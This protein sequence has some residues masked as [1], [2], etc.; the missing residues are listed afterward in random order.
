MAPLPQHPGGG[1]VEAL[2]LDHRRLARRLAQRYVRNGDQREDLEQAAYLGLVKAARRFDP[3]RGVAFTTFAV[4]TVLGELRRFC[5]DTRWAVHV[6]RAIQEHVQAFRKVEDELLLVHGR[7]PSVAEM[8]EALGWSQEDVLDAREAAGCL[9]PQSLNAPMRSA[10]DTIGEAIECI[11]DD[12]R[13]FAAVEQRDELHCALAL[14]SARE[15]RAVQL[16]GEGGCSTPEIARHLG[17]S[18]PQ[19]A[20]LVAHSIRRLRDAFDEIATTGATQPE[21]F[22]RLADADPDL[23]AGVDHRARR[24]A[25]ARRER[26]APGEWPGPRAEGLGMLV[27]SGALLR[28]V[29]VDDRPHAELIG[30]GD[31]IRDAD[32]E[33]DAHWRAVTTVDLAVLEDSLCRWPPVVEALLRRASDRSHAL[34]VQLAITDLRR[35]E[36]R[37]LAFFRVLADRWGTRVSDGIVVSM[38]L[39]HDMIAMIVGVHRPT[40]STTLRRLETEYRLRRRGHDRWVLTTGDAPALPLAA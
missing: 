14:L 7:S 39:T 30:P 27:L 37:V 28:M 4:P 38:P 2:V 11:G 25:V 12:D 24:G 23:F 20:R 32:G 40:V 13:G 34:A 35:A 1:D 3:E 18:T 22:V 9:A 26:L 6:P 5:R 29:T 10:D 17:I 19:A 8:A 33:R 16:R 36:D 15:R 21:R 31:V